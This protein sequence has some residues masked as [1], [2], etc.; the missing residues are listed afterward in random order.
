M[1]TLA[2]LPKRLHALYLLVQNLVQPSQHQKQR[3]VKILFEAIALYM[4]DQNPPVTFNISDSASS[5]SLSVEISAM[6]YLGSCLSVNKVQIAPQINESQEGT[7]ITSKG[8]LT[9]TLAGLVDNILQLMIAFNWVQAHT[10]VYSKTTQKIRKQLVKRGV[11]PLQALVTIQDQLKAGRPCYNL[12][13]AF[14][15]GGVCGL[16]VCSADYHISSAK[17]TLQLLEFRSILK[18]KESFPDGNIWKCTE[19]YICE[20][21]HE[22]FFLNHSSSPLCPSKY[23]LEEYL[24]LDFSEALQKTTLWSL[25]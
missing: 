11:D 4:D 24:A 5:D 19:K 10:K 6:H 14:L 1:S 23:H 15:T 25:N 22:S 13:S 18:R 20:F 2:G 17:G 3:A 7:S 12:I 16:Q 8:M 21:L 9:P